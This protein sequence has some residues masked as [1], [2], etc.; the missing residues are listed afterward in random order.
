[1]FVFWWEFLY[2][3]TQPSTQ[4]SGSFIDGAWHFCL[5]NACTLLHVSA[6]V[7]LIVWDDVEPQ[8]NDTRFIA[9]CGVFSAV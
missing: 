3:E 5:R 1:M 8:A 2:Q 7:L 6:S 9:K 4:A